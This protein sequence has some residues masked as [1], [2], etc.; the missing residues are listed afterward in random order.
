[1]AVK[2]V[3]RASWHVLQ[4]PIR[5]CSRIRLGSALQNLHGISVERVNTHNSTRNEFR[6]KRQNQLFTFG[7]SNDDCAAFLP[8]SQF[9]ASLFLWNNPHSIVC[10]WKIGNSL[11]AAR[12]IGQRIDID[13]II[14]FDSFVVSLVP[15]ACAI[16]SVF[17][18]CISRLNAAQNC[19][20]YFQRTIRL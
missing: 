19:L 7:S 3:F 10:M 16:S 12:L 18:M 4:S 6:H 1:M 5:F 11:P 17:N 15:S 8:P 13:A 14:L 20:F 9:S 2:A